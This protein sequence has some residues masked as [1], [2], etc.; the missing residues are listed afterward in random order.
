MRRARATRCCCSTAAT[1][2]GGR[3]WRRSPSAAAALAVEALTRP[4]ALG[5]DLELVVALVKRARLET[6]VEKA[7]ELG[8]RRVRLAITAAHQRRPHQR[9]AP[10]RHRHR[11]RR[12]DRAA[13]RARDRRARRSWSDLLD[14]W[15][16]G[17]PLM[18]CDEAGD[19]PPML[20]GAGGPRGRAARRA[21]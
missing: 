2:N 1:A 4:Q 21:S 10:D 7:A 3:R 12:A 8:A 6:I 15:H 5:P 11:G 19:A 18:F 16:A 14:G 20:D 13:G 9:R 17:R